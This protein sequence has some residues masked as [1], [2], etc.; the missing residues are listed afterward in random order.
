MKRTILYLFFGLFVFVSAFLFNEI[1]Q[2]HTHASAMQ[3][4]IASLASLNAK[5][6]QTFSHYKDKVFQTVDRNEQQ[7]KKT[8]EEICYSADTFVHHTKDLKK[9]ILNNKEGRTTL[10]YEKL[11][12]Q[13]KN[14]D[15]LRGDFQRASRQI[16]ELTDHVT[17]NNQRLKE[18]MIYPTVQLRGKGTVGSGIIV[19]SGPVKAK[20]QQD[21]GT[22]SCATYIL[23]AYH[24]ILEVAASEDHTE[25]KDIRIMGKGDV[26]QPTQYQGTMVACD[27]KVDIALIKLDLDRPLPFVAMFESPEKLAEIELFEVTYT[28]GC[29][30]GNMPLPTAGQI[31]TKHKNVQNNILWMFNAPTF[32]GNSGGGVFR[33]KNGKLIGV[34]SM[35]YTYG[36]STP[37]VV[38]HLGLFIPAEDIFKW[39]KKERYDFIL[40]G[41]RRSE[42]A[43][44][45]IRAEKQP[46]TCTEMNSNNID[47]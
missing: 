45:E 18:A 43:P 39:L 27:K 25:I 29:P 26:L 32:F 4:D 3:K 5:L 17:Q 1:M 10:V 36:E 35:V 7:W 40:T 15:A 11:K 44:D 37:V 20:Q 24:V 19:Y 14:M 6:L 33:A 28:V 47:I 42:A 22:S 13:D 41:T 23:S 34:T 12:A 46:R 21:R 30:L 8:I 16:A 2:F 38:P 31:T 9:L